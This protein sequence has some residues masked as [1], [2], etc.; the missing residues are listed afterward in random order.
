VSYVRNRKVTITLAVVVAALL[1]PVG[2]ATAT[3][4]TDGF[5]YFDEYGIQEIHDSGITGKGVTIGVIDGQIN[6]DVPT[7]R[8]A[9][10]EL[11]PS[12]CYDGSGTLMPVTSTDISEDHGTNVVSYL[13]GSGEGYPGQTGVK[14]IVPDAK[15]IYT[16]VGPDN[17]CFDVEGKTHS[18]LGDGIYAA[19]D[20]GADLISIS[21]SGDFDGDSFIAITEALNKG[22]PVF[23]GDRNAIGNGGV[24]PSGANGVV[25][26]R[27][28]DIDLNP[29]GDSVTI[30]SSRTV[31]VGPG[32]NVV[33]QGDETYEQQSYATGTS[34]ATPI[35]AGF[36]AL[37]AQKYPDATG[38]QLIQS[39]VRNT[40][41]EDHELSYD[42]EN[43]LYGYGEASAKHML[44][45]DPT[46]YDDVN[47]LISDSPD[48]TP[49]L[50][51][52]QNPPPREIIYDDD[53]IA[54]EEPVDGSAVAA[55][56]FILLGI[57]LLGLLVLAGIITL[58]IVLVVRRGRTKPQA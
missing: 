53:P 21:L 33:W 36:M 5:W 11:Q 9:D 18:A 15:I 49:T 30:R 22:I 45:V 17:V 37:T 7:L 29:S 39:L 46:Q 50:E 1:V 20:A 47:L 4:A 10:I 42:F 34:I 19:I 16:S 32:V 14:G 26:V 48:E 8:G 54:A 13:V 12:T 52:I 55:G 38:N 51:E 3:P 57:G 35:V 56:L 28:I 23:A 24:W 43:S 2:G 31:V 40:W 27:A 58:I 41:L 44:R 6:L 25:A